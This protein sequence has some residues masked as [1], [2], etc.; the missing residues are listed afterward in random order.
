MGLQEFIWTRLFGVSCSAFHEKA[1]RVK[2]SFDFFLIT[3]VTPI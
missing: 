2:Y 1:N 3:L